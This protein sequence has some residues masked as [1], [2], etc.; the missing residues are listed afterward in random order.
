MIRTISIFGLLVTT[1][2]IGSLFG[3]LIMYLTFADVLEKKENA[4]GKSFSPNPP[5][6]V[7]P[8]S[9]NPD[10]AEMTAFLQTRR[11]KLARRAGSN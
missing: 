5:V 7:F 9:F 10:K 8:V 4:Q 6:Y 11:T 1:F 3:V 2:S